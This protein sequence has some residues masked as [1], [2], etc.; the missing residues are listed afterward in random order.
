MV[1]GISKEKIRN[2]TTASQQT[3]DC[4]HDQSAAALCLKPMSSGSLKAFTRAPVKT[5]F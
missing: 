2:V 3:K 1:P 5:L 4:T